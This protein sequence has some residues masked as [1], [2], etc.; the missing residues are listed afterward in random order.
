MSVRNFFMKKQFIQ[1]AIFPGL[2]YFAKIDTRFI[3]MYLQTQYSELQC[4]KISI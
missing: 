3:N 4:K 2:L 1:Y